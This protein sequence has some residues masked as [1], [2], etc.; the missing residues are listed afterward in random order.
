VRATRRGEPARQA[1]Q[2]GRGGAERP[3]LLAALRAVA[4]RAQAGGHAGLVHVK[5]TADGV[6]DLHRSPRFLRRTV[7][8]SP[9]GR[10]YA[11]CTAAGTQQSGVPGSAWVPIATGSVAP[12]CSRPRHRACTSPPYHGGIFHAPRVTPSGSWADSNCI[13]GKPLTLSSTITF[14]PTARGR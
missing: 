2:L 5:G 14:S 10:S 6:E 9:R 1:Q 13:L 4:G 11:C 8:R 12:F 3:H 7:R